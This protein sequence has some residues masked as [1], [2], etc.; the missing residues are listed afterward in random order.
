MDREYLLTCTYCDEYTA[1]HRF[2][3]KAGRFQGEYSL[4][5]NRHLE[6]D[7]LLCKFLTAHVGHPVRLIPN[8]TDEY[9]NI[10]TRFR[11]FAEED[12]DRY[13]EEAREQAKH[14]QQDRRFDR[15]LGQ[16]QLLIAKKLLQEEAEGLSRIAAN[17]DQAQFLLGKQLG[18]EW[19]MHTISD[20]L[21]KGDLGVQDGGHGK[22][23]LRRPDSPQTPDP[24]SS[25]S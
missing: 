1:L 12:V 18:I 23:L 13:V 19:A 16:L 20:I 15:G 11:R 14:Q 3:A 21:L 25:T 5:H 7:A 24:E 10:I 22:T 9:T 4:L 17:P 2:I 6:S 8:R